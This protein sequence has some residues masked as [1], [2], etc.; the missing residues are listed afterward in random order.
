[1]AG[2]RAARPTS[3]L[4]RLTMGFLYCRGA[5]PLE[6]LCPAV[7]PKHQPNGVDGYQSAPCG[8]TPD[9][10]RLPVRAVVVA[11]RRG[12]VAMMDMLMVIVALGFFA[13][14]LGYAY[15]CDRL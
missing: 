1:M 7:P 9:C 3:P 6:N 8:P 10:I 15:A 13:L 12:R 11:S 14:S 2:P 5:F 4:G